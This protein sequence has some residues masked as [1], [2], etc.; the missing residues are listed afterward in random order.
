MT[1]RALHGLNVT[2]DRVLHAPDLMGPPDRPHVFV[3]FITISNES[4]E[5]VTIKG[6]KW[7]IREANGDTIAV[8]GDGVV[9]EFPRLEPGGRFS[10]NSSHAA[11]FDAVAE[12]AY[13]GVTD[14]GEPVFTRIP[15]FEMRIPPY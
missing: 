14:T 5:T 11:A 3:Y 12:G 13:L 7:V 8:E 10:Y 1:P 2:V 15:R 4:D 9:G 6:R